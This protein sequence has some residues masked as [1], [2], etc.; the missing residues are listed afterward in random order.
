MLGLLRRIR[1][2]L[3]ARQIDED[4]AQEIEAHRALAQRDLERRGLAPAEAHSA[5]RR[6][7][8]NVTL[9]RE[10][11]RH[12]WGWPSVDRLWQDVRYGTRMLR[13]NRSFTVVA[14]A[15][16]ALGI[17]ASTAMFSVVNAVLLRPLPFHDPD[18]LVAIWIADPSRDIREAGTSFPTVVDW[19][20][21]NRR[22]ADLAI[23]T[24]AAARIRAGGDPERVATGFVSASLF[25]V[26]G[27]TP[28]IGRVFTADE[29]GARERV[30]VL[31]HALWQRRFGSSRDVLGQ[32][33]EIDGETPEGAAE[34]P[35][36]ARIIGV[37]PEGFFFPDRETQ[38]WRPATLLGIDGKPKLYERQWTDRHADRWRVIGRLRP[39]ATEAIAEAD[40]DLIGA[41]LADAFPTPLGRAEFPGFAVDVVSLQEQFTGRNLRLALWILLGAVSLVLLIACAN[42]ANLLLARGTGRQREFAIRAALGAGHGRIVRQLAVESLLLASLAGLLGLAAS[43]AAIRFLASSMPDILRLNE[44]SIDSTVLAFTGVVA[45]LAALVFGVAPA[46]KAARAGHHDGLKESP[47]TSSHGL[48]VRNV[49]GL[50]V[51]V[52]CAMAVVLLAGAGLLVRSFVRLYAVDPGFDP[53]GVLLVRVD[54]AIPVGEGW[55][56]REWAT[57]RDIDERIRT[58][59]GVR[60]AGFIQNFRI[61]SNPRTPV[62]FEIAPTEVEVLNSPQG[63]LDLTGVNVEEVT[64]GFFQAMAVPLRQGRF[65]TYA[66]QNQPLAIVNEE[67]VSRFMRG[68]NPIG[69]RFSPGTPGTKMNWHTIVAIVGNMR[70]QGLDQKPVP[71]FFIPSTEPAMD[72]VV[73]VDGDPAAVA[74]A[75]REQIRA[76]HDGAIV[77]RMSTMDAF[78]GEWTAERRFQ[79]WLLGA[80]ATLALVLAAVGIYGVMQFAAAQRMKELS[81]RVALGARGLDLMRLMIGQGL[82]L[83]MTGLAIGL[84]G[85]YLLVGLLQSLL[86]EVSPADPITFAGVALLLGVMAI[87]ACYVPAW[88]ASRVDPIVALRNE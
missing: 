79:T 10:D 82:R 27:V 85:A 63:G 8:G 6:A 18:R 84:L 3:R 86:F 53:R 62:A 70:R 47:A 74:S 88:R 42:V 46:W 2:L 81:I 48:R 19:R 15:T 16:L 11:A 35:L 80:F 28:A 68:E 76:V 83:P 36:R 22:F 45:L 41:R 72:L 64:P 13:R 40:L 59:P 9:A 61:A 23:W 20:T 1:Q 78:L 71:E 24:T 32:F 21:Q 17:G 73:R 50:L 25:S 54:S 55:R 66:E 34:P 87:P 37:M 60:Q 4:L 77:V 65:F 38:F 33:L 30:V 39:G 44:I 52:E 29:E 51:V 14:V 49:R 69:R 75:V 57:F 26:L 12:I 56:E 43:G 31:S 7:I 5:S 58:I 67:F